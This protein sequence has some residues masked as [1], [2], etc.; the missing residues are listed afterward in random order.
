MEERPFRWAIASQAW[1]GGKEWVEDSWLAVASKPHTP[2][3][4]AIIYGL[5]VLISFLARGGRGV[6]LLLTK[7]TID[8]ADRSLTGWAIRHRPSANAFPVHFWVSWFI[9]VSVVGWV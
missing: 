9:L 1:V 7:S 8:C 4:I 3:A 6:Y 5:V 2:L